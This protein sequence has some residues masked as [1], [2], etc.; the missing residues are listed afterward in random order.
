MTTDPALAAPVFGENPILSDLLRMAAQLQASYRPPRR[1]GI[2]REC[3]TWLTVQ[4][5]E[6]QGLEVVLDCLEAAT[7]AEVWHGNSTTFSAQASLA[8]ARAAAFA[9]G[10]GMTPDE[11]RV[12]IL[13]KAFWGDDGRQYG[14]PQYP[15]VEHPYTS[16]DFHK[17]RASL[18]TRLV[19]DQTQFRET[20]ELRLIM[21]MKGLSPFDQGLS[22]MDRL[23]LVMLSH[24]QVPPAFSFKHLWLVR[25][26]DAEELAC[27]MQWLDELSDETL[28]RSDGREIM[29]RAVSMFVEVV[30][31]CDRAGIEN[32]RVI[33]GHIRAMRTSVG[34]VL[35]LR[36]LVGLASRVGTQVGMVLEDRGVLEFEMPVA[37]DIFMEVILRRGQHSLSESDIDQLLAFARLAADVFVLGKY[38]L[39]QQYKTVTIAEY[40]AAHPRASAERLADEINS[41]RGIRRLEDSRFRDLKRQFGSVV[42]WKARRGGYGFA[43]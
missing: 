32:A 35:P 8:I 39:D 5:E 30:A 9:E 29:G 26:D 13:H 25:P 33:L 7:A 27:A 21:A 22:F 16:G 40:L 14:R 17:S 37:I 3:A 1:S 23:L 12:L 11:L 38:I 2:I 31:F 4:I 20:N 36:L 28:P 42:F 18:P 15:C 6:A 41:T 43:S 19:K 10:M 34:A 24:R